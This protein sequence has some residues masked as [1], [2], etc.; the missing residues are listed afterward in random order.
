MKIL[1][2]LI[3][4]LEVIVFLGALAALV[5][6]RSVIF[7]SN[8]NY[9]LDKAIV[10]AEEVFKIEI[11]SH[12]SDVE[13]I[14]ELAQSECPAEVNTN[15]DAVEGTVEHVAEVNAAVLAEPEKLAPVEEEPIIEVKAEEEE[16]S[17]LIETLSSAVDAMNKKVDMLFESDNA[18]I[19]SAAANDIKMPLKNLAVDEKD[20]PA[21]N[22]IDDPVV[23]KSGQSVGNVKQGIFMA[24]QLFWNGN[25]ADSEKIYL[26]LT[27][28][29]NSD[30]DIYGEL[31]NV[32]YAQGKWKLA[33]EAYYEAAIRLMAN[34]GNDGH[35]A[36]V[37]H[38]LKVIQGID[39]ESA[40]K[41]RNK[42]SG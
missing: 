22:K 13:D 5:Y 42:I 34:K 9:Y 39:A 30:P 26:N 4:P 38:L 6:F 23:S 31:G 27:R 37:S 41:L 14:K 17:A 28:L 16:K 19:E 1:K 11:P 20:A 33:G 18:K 32:Y 8:V 10:S 3:K 25:P 21:I 36:E 2:Y 40:T 7:H 29:D 35:M 24:R 12:E 15:N